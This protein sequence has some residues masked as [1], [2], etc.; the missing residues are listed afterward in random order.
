LIFTKA[1]TKWQ[2]RNS[3][4]RLMAACGGLSRVVG[5]RCSELSNHLV[6]AWFMV[7]AK[8]RSGFLRRARAWFEF[9]RRR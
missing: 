8:P 2:M 7:S 4:A 1:R 3:I 5:A 6:E 9:N